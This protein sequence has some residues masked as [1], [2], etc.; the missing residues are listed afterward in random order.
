MESWLAGLTNGGQKFVKK[1]KDDAG[2]K[3]QRLRSASAN[4]VES[5]N[6]SRETG[7]QGDGFRSSETLLAECEKFANIAT[8]E[9][10][11]EAKCFTWS[12]QLCR[13][14]G[15]EPKFEP[16]PLEQAM[17]LLPAEEQARVWMHAEKLIGGDGT[18]ENDVH[19]VLADGR[20]RIL[21]S[22]ATRI[23]TGDGRSRKILGLS[24]DVTEHRAKEGRPTESEALL[25]RAE[26]FGNLG[27]WELHVRTGESM[28]S[29]QL[30]RV[31]GLPPSHSS[32]QQAYWNGLHSLDRVRIRETLAEAIRCEKEFD[33]LARYQFPGGGWRVLRIHGFPI[34]EGDGKT[35][36]MMGVVQDIT[37]QTRAEQELHQLSQRL[38]RA[39][40]EER[41][42]T[43]RELHES[44]GQSLAA[45]KMALANLSEALPKRKLAANSLLQMC[46]DLADDAA[47]EV[48]TVSYLM[49]PPMLDEAGL[50]SALRWY[51]KGFSERSKIQVEVNI[52]EDFGRQSEEIEMT[53]FRIIQE[54]LTNVH[55]YSGSRVAKIRLL[56]KGAYVLAEVEDEGCGI[57]R[58]I[59]PTGRPGEVGVGIAGMRERVH[60]LNGTFG[61]ESSPGRGTVVRA[62]LPISGGENNNGVERACKLDFHRNLDEPRRTW[63]DAENGNSGNQ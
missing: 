59:A 46:A 12:D 56:K 19:L 14:L 53:L 33:E 2:G 41:R 13:M 31:L 43:A 20:A 34:V 54:A 42:N 28:W 15:C 44:A 57:A 63:R 51:A 40:D 8:W 21:R 52:P 29:E 17:R 3:T 23:A 30:F 55:R 27:S 47:R 35:A 60:Q 39:R 61:I 25:A 26:E 7:V 50:A 37:E 10:D 49:H 58:P 45:L 6:L 48:R 1:E 5:T 22:H 62:T 16:V 24:Q 18:V 36:R 38:M 9:Y 32:K 4:T 11:I